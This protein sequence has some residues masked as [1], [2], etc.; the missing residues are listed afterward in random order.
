[1][2]RATS[3]DTTPRIEYVCIQMGRRLIVSFIS[4]EMVESARSCT[5]RPECAGAEKLKTI[6]GI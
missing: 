6:R 1:M 2:G 3:V 5:I 4:E